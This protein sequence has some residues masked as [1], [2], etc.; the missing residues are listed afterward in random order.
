MTLPHL[1]LIGLEIYLLVY[2]VKVMVS[3]IKEIINDN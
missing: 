1:I 3:S 2:L